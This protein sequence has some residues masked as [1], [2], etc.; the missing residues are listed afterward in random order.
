MPS[1]RPTTHISFF[2]VLTWPE[3]HNHSHISLWPHVGIGKL[4]GAEVEPHGSWLLWSG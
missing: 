1:N 4:V 2:R 3:M